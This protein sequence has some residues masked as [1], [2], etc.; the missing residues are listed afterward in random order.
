[1]LVTIS[2]ANMLSPNH[3]KTQTH[4]FTFL[5]PKHTLTMC[6]W[7]CSCIGLMILGLIRKEVRF[8]IARVG[9]FVHF[10]ELLLLLLWHKLVSWQS[11]DLFS[12][13][14]YW[15]HPAKI[16]YERVVYCPEAL[17]SDA[18]WKKKKKRGEVLHK[19]KLTT[20]KHKLFLH[21][22]DR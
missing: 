12:L 17:L 18:V 4:K 22:E 3:L 7:G 2:S 8:F 21:M 14:K 19:N 10:E 15:M 11:C 5:H 6:G 20:H 13:L 16:S 9:Q 1:L